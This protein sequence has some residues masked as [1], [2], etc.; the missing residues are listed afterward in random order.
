MKF[1]TYIISDE[2]QK[3]LIETGNTE[4]WNKFYQINYIRRTPQAPKPVEV[5][6]TEGKPE[7]V[8]P[9]VNN[10][11]SKPVEDEIQTPVVN[12]PEKDTI[13]NS[14]EPKT[15]KPAEQV[16]V[17]EPVVAEPTIGEMV[18][19]ESDTIKNIPAIVADPVQESIENPEP[20]GIYTSEPEEGH[21]LIYLLPV[22]STNQSLLTTYLTRL[23][24]TNFR[25]EGLTISAEPLDDIMVMVIVKGLPNKE[26][27]QSYYTFTKND[28]RIIMSLKNVS[29]KS[30]LIS[31]NNLQKLKT[32]K[33]I[34][35]YQQFHEKNY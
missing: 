19:S 25:S 9:E 21:N 35:A 14:T 23:N 24:A 26:K 1:E 12:T 34:A 16:L 15:E 28:Q 27:A 17:T 18:I 30:Y 5:K 29:Y 7:D 8:K 4:E 33:D 13:Q 2:N 20:S 11:N 10:N 3:K 6:P 22:R 32:T 31:N